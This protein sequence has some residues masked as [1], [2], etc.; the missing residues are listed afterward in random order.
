M[1]GVVRAKEEISA[2][3]LGSRMGTIT[4]VEVGTDPA[5][6]L[7]LNDIEKRLAELEKEMDKVEKALVILNKQ[8]FNLPPEKAEMKA[9]IT[10]T[11][12]VMKGEKRKLEARRDEILEEMTQRSVDRGRIKY[13]IIFPG[14]RVII[15]KAVGSSKTRCVIPS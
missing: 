5:S 11:S 7:E 14:V 15:G 8:G 10:R 2:Q 13:K 9:R 6:R 12:F 3:V 1:G 4:E